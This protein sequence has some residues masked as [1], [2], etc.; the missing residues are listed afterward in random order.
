MR[1]KKVDSSIIYSIGYDRE[2]SVLE[3]EFIDGAIYQYPGIPYREYLGLMDSGSQGKYYLRYI[4]DLY[5]SI[6]IKKGEDREV[7]Y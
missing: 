4:R 1:R 3:M 7:L 6:L 2:E 5:P